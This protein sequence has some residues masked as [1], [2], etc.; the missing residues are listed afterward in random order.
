MDG[1]EV[2]SDDYRRC[3]ADL[4]AVNRV[5]LTHGP[6]LRWLDRVTAG[7]PSAAPLSILDVGC[8]QGDLLRAIH[9]WAQRRGRTVTLT[10]LDLNP[11]SAT[12]ARD[13]TPS[14]MAIAWRTGDVFAYAPSPRPDLIV[15]S[16]FAHHLGDDQVV[17][18]LRWLDRYAARGWFIA[19]LQRHWFA[20]Y[21]F[22]WLARLAGW[23]RIVRLD[24][25]L[26][27]A[28]SFRRAEWRELLGRAGV[29]GE[30]R[31]H[32]PFRICVARAR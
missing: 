23:H 5:T 18:L 6:T 17:E 13:A 30:I 16:Q 32:V 21:G 14:G 12:A 29:E 9:R 4:A 22:R 7:W 2:S 11:A 3:L 15:S 8:G 10:G 1:P 31:W 28:R 19:D 26:S 25:T 24:G 20:Y 27:I